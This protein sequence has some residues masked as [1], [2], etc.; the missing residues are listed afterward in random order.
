MQCGFARRF[1]V[2]LH[3]GEV[4]PSEQVQ[5]EE[6]L[7]D[8]SECRLRYQ[9]LAD[10]IPAPELSVPPAVGNR[11]WAEVTADSVLA[12]VDSP[13]TFRPAPLP[14][15]TAAALYG[16]GGLAGLLLA[17]AVA[18]WLPVVDPLDSGSDRL[19]SASFGGVDLEDP[20][21]YGHTGLHRDVARH[22]GTSSSSFRGYRSGVT[23]YK[24]DGTR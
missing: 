16:G 22:D 20:H 18:A 19:A 7:A 14:H 12:E 23:P 8:C 10:L 4:S 2:A 6:H 1:L 24:K 11:L 15:R 13:K 9:R 17:A 5:L 3:D 21:S